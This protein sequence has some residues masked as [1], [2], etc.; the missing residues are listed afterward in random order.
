MYLT[1]RHFEPLATTDIDR[2]TQAVAYDAA[3]IWAS[4]YPEHHSIRR[5]ADAIDRAVHNHHLPDPLCSPHDSLRVAFEHATRAVAYAEAQ[6]WDD[7]CCMAA[8]AVQ[9]LSGTHI[10]PPRTDPLID[11]T[12]LVRST[13]LISTA[14]GQ[15][16]L[17]WVCHRLQPQIDLRVRDLAGAYLQLG[18]YDTIQ[19]AFEHAA[20]TVATNPAS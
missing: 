2:L 7:E 17:E 12:V 13:N 9:H 6:A 14:A 18:T 20:E 15:T 3:D 1:A 16:P 19:D 5:A 4:H 10:V 8:Y 11:R